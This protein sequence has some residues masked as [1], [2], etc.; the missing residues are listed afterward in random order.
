MLRLW[1]LLRTRAL[2]VAEEGLHPLDTCT[3]VE[4]TVSASVAFADLESEGTDPEKEPTIAELVDLLFVAGDPASVAAHRVKVLSDL[5]ARSRS[6]REVPE[7]KPK[8]TLERR[9]KNTEKECRRSTRS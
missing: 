2:L 7:R 4:E 6:A 1:L 8:Q 5:V 9:K 3:S